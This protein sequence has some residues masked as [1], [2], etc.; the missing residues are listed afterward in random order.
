VAPG[1]DVVQSAPEL[2]ALLRDNE[3]SGRPLNVWVPS[4]ATL[5]LNGSRISVNAG[6]NLTIRSDGPGAVVDGQESSY[7]FD[8]FAGAALE[9]HN[10][11]LR[12]G[13]GSLTGGIWTG[14]H[15]SLWSVT[16]EGCTACLETSNIGGGVFMAG[17]SVVLTGSQISSCTASAPTVCCSRG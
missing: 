15:V 4:G 10:L 5:L 8:V 2:R 9:I 6:L 11:V 14:G 12:R 16:L 17:G 7:L 3:A 13:T 1:F